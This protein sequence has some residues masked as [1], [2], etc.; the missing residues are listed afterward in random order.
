MPPGRPTSYSEEMLTLANAYIDS[1]DTVVP[2]A[3]GMALAL[4][5]SK[6]TLYNWADQ[7]PDFLHTLD[8]LNQKQENLLLHKGV[9][10]EFNSTITKLMLANHGYHDKQDTNLNANIDIVEI[11][12][13]F[14]EE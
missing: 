7:H 4:N 6:K 9:T 12:D 11:K 2:N 14:G 3:A 8:K 10:G 5:V 1:E 13:D